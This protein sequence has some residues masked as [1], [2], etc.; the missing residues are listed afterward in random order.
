V[1]LELPGQPV[2]VVHRSAPWSRS[3]T[4]MTAQAAPV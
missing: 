3:V 1:G 2:A 4:D